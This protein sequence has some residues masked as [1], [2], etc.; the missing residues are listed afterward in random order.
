MPRFLGIETSG[1]ET[2]VALVEAGQ[3]VAEGRRG[4]CNHNEELL[5]LIDTVL[6]QAET[7]LDALAGIGVTS[8]PGMFTSLRVGLATAA[9]L[10]LPRGIPVKGIST[11]AALAASVT[12][13]STPTLAVIDARRQ[14]VYAALYQEEK[15]LVPPAT[16]APS[17]LPAFLESLAPDLLLLLAGSGTE[18]CRSHLTDR[19]VEDS[20]IRSPSAT[21]VARLAAEA[22]AQAGDDDLDRLAPLYL[23]RTD[24]EINRAR[25]SG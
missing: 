19:Q 12:D 13:D 21:A 6:S 9:A 15:E 22:I 17:G 24:A 16:L 20:G 25:R 10:A 23:R 3:T 14:Q 18:L 2:R 5:P 1:P 11:L 8:G 7:T 4:G